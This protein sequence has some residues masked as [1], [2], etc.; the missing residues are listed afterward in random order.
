MEGRYNLRPRASGRVQTNNTRR[1]QHYV[2]PA[3]VP[4]SSDVN[5]L[6]QALLS[7]EECNMKLASENTALRQQFANLQGENHKLM[8]ENRCLQG[9][10]GRKLHMAKQRVNDLEKALEVTK[11]GPDHNNWEERVREKERELSSLRETLSAQ[12]EETE[13]V[14]D[15]WMKDCDKMKAAFEEELKM[16]KSTCDTQRS[17]DLQEI[18]ANCERKVNQLQ[19]EMTEKDTQISTMRNEIKTLN[20][21]FKKELVEREESWER[22]QKEAEKLWAQREDALVKKA[23]EAEEELKTVIVKSINLQELVLKKK[24]KKEKKRGLWS[25]ERETS[26]RVEEETA[27]CSAQAGQE[28]KKKEKEEK[29]ESRRGFWGKNK[30]KSN[31]D[32]E[33]SVCLTQ[34]GQEQKEKDKIKRR[35]SLW[36]KKKQETSFEEE[37]EEAAVCQA[38]VGQDEE[39]KEKKR[40]YWSWA[41]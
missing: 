1:P 12:K 13:K 31:G 35:G 29:K 16:V 27:G 6:R 2:P 23:S 11:S 20:E 39:I 38:E 3:G 9:T 37:E 33:A 40:S 21:K 26:S 19:E 10:L 18:Q 32:K 7:A 15:S 36:S 41:R 34:T 14:R 30:E 28:G 22:R 24:K 4:P 5:S 8:H 17:S 25:R